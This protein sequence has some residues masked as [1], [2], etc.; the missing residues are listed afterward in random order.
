MAEAEQQ[1]R[2]DTKLIHGGTVP[3]PSGATKPPIVQA[4]AFAYQTAEELEDV[5]KG[6][7]VGQVYTRIGNPTLEGLEKRLAV[8]E[9][10]IAAVI[11]SSGMSAITTAVMA[12]VRCG[13][14][15]LSSASLFGGTYSLFHDTLANYGIKTRFFD[16]TD[17]GALEAGI[18]ERTRL[19]FVETIGNPKMDVP[20]IE[21]FSAIA[22]KSG[23]PLMV[24]ATVSTPYLARMRDLGADIIIHSTSKYINGTANSI[25]GAI[26][27]AGS[28]D[29][30]SDRFPHFEPFRRKYRNFAFTARVRKL[31][32]KDFGAC[33]A[34]LNAFLSGEGLDTLALRMERHCSN[35]LELA[36]FLE[37]HPKVAWVNYPGLPD[38]P[39]HEVAGRQFN[40]RFGGLLTFGLA[41][42]PAAFRLVNA[43]R[44]AKN[45]AN[46]GDT[47]TLVIH[48]ASTIC[49]DYTPEVKRL[50]GVSEE[51]VRV[52][53][54]IED[55]ADIVED[56]S[57]ALER[58]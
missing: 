56:F 17:L 27:D 37:S 45:L 2:F 54:G 44:L 3:G 47:K 30:G 13:D 19:I 31:I 1:L 48:P 40:G 52:S 33:A 34:P 12:V 55:P 29:W 4:S 36:R 50:M 41:D 24:D 25:G 32:H 38:S 22:K 16:P 9:N 58:V 53:V 46:I 43:L 10:G 6:R 51:L 8:I 28:F 15:I 7:A 35:A 11:T 49:A 21:A 18:S 5:F 57:A 14:E 42:K 23:I 39:F 26:I 20:D